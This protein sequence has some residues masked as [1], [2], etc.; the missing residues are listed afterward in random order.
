MFEVGSAGGSV[1]GFQSRAPRVGV[2][3]CLII[4]SL[5]SSL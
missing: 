4:L 1:A 5:G 3:I 2:Q